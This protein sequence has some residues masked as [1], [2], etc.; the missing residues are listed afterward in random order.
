MGKGNDMFTGVILTPRLPGAVLL[1]DVVWA[2]WFD[3]LAHQATLLVIKLLIVAGAYLVGSVLGVLLAVALNRWVFR[4]RMP[5]VGKQLCSLICGLLLALLA[6]LFVLGSGG[7]GL[8]GG[9]GA[10]NGSGEG[11]N[12]SSAPRVGN[13]ASPQE[14]THETPSPTPSVPPLHREVSTVI[15]VTVLA[16]KAVREAGRFYLLDDDPNPRTFSEI[17]EAILL[18]RSRTK[19]R[20]TVQ[21]L[22]PADPNLAPPQNDPKVTR[23]TEWVRQEAGLD[24]AF[25]SRSR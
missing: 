15:R 12:S 11:A 4:K 19:E 10:G 20:L 3:H 16:G 9:G 22:F 21:I 14:E 6:A 17:T 8:W 23:L 7:D 5:E 2:N 1:G 25:P 24:V 13:H 18:R